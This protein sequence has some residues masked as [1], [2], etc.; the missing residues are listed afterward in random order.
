M[1]STMSKTIHS[2]SALENHRSES[3]RAGHGS[4]GLA[5]PRWATRAACL[6]I[7]ARRSDVL[8]ERLDDGAVLV[9]PPRGN[10]YLPPQS[11][12]AVGVALL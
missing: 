10:S 4:S 1:N 3:A 6:V 9:D 11:D 8:E 7:P 2:G 5:C 12:R